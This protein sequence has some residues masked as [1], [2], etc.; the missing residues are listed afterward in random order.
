[1]H[2]LIL[3]EREMKEMS[4]FK[5]VGRELRTQPLPTKAGLK[6]PKNLSRHGDKS[7]RTTKVDLTK[8]AF[9]GRTRRS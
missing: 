2:K 8:G 5:N 4:Q 6:D 7:K 1:M 9:G 3:T